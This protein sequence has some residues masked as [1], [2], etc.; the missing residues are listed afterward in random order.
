MD[1]KIIEHL[2]DGKSVTQIQKLLQKGKE[3]I[4]SIR[5]L[6]V[7]YNYIEEIIFGEKRYID[8]WSPQTIFEEIKTPISNATFYRYM[9]RNN[10]MQSSVYQKS[11]EEI[12]HTTGE[13][14]QVDWAKLVMRLMH[15]QKRKKP[16]L[17][18]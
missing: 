11:P 3:Y 2:I 9:H 13:C 14:L 17:F 12:I 15:S 6:A 10:F 18:F 16:F 8:G 4:I 1:R 5:D 7:E